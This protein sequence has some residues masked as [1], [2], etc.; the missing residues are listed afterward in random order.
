MAER[1]DI[2]H[3]MTTGV[4]IVSH[5][6]VEVVHRKRRLI[7][8]CF[9]RQCVEKGSFESRRKADDSGSRLRPT[10]AVVL[11]WKSGWTMLD[12]YDIRSVSHEVKIR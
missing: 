8:S 12:S 6:E 10:M 7:K 9:R 1:T 11:T 2:R 4:G 3:S 5:W